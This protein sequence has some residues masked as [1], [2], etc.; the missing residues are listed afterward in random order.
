[1]KD[2]YDDE[3]EKMAI[4]IYEATET[5]FKYVANEGYEAY[6]R[7]KLSAIKAA[8][9]LAELLRDKERLDGIIK[10]SATWKSREICDEHLAAVRE[11][12]K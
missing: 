7:R 1:M 4:E 5:H 8:I 10:Y 2:Q 6:R 9:P 11:E 12:K 3:A